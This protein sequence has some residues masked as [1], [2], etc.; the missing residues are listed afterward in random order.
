M[1]LLRRWEAFCIQRNSDPFL[2]SV[3]N[4]LEFLNDLHNSGCQY[5]ALCTARSALASV[6]TVQG[7][8]SLSDHPMIHRYL[9]GIYNR[10]SPMPKY[11]QVGD[12]NVILN[13]SDKA[14]PNNELSFKQLTVK[15]AMLLMIPGAR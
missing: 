13:F 11:I 5:R 8:P 4:V 3:N 12:L 14:P 6:V 9:K 10:N 7:F 15:V 1:K 2:S